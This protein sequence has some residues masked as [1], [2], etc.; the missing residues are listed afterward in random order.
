M[1]K[2][3]G[4]VVMALTLCFMT[5]CFPGATYTT[6]A[7]VIDNTNHKIDGKEYDNVT[8]RCWKVTTTITGTATGDFDDGDA[9]YDGKPQVTI[10]Y[11]WSDEFTLRCTCELARY[12]GNYT[13]SGGSYATG[14]MTF[15]YSYEMEVVEGVDEGQCNE[16][17]IANL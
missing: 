11:E 1:K 14:G 12:A 8:Y 16:D 10:D 4:F 17:D 7:P 6:S 3:L 2:F 5:G 15:T 9:E 13:V